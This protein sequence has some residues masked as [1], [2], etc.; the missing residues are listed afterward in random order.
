MEEIKIEEVPVEENDTRKKKII[1]FISRLIGYVLV[2]LGCPVAFLIWK[3]QLF[4]TT[5]KLNIGG[6]GIVVVIMTAI[7]LSKLAKQAVEAIDSVL[8]K[9]ILDAFR[10]VLVPLLAITLCLYSVG[11]YWQYLIYFFMILTICEP[12]AYVLNPMP[13]LLKDKEIAKQ[14]NKILQIIETFWDKKR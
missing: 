12:I 10:K 8:I 2:G 7:F 5:T 6:W 1:I 4:S 14:E 9:Q 11:E 3:F 13:E